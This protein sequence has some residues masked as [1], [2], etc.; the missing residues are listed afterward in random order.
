MKKLLVTSWCVCFTG[1]LFSQSGFKVS[2]FEN[3]ES[4]LTDKMG[5]NRY[6]AQGN[7]IGYDTI[8]FNLKVGYVNDIKQEEAFRWIN[9]SFDDIVKVIDDCASHRLEEL[10]LEGV[11]V[12]ILGKVNRMAFY[13]KDGIS[14]FVTYQKSNMYRAEGKCN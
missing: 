12:N 10:T 5:N 9:R 2:G 7:F 14:Y 4:S 1:L 8:E 3:V 11:F 13:F 6:I